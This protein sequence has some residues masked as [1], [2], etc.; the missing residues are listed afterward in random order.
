MLPKP[1][2]PSPPRTRSPL[3]SLNPD[4]STL[5]SPPPR[6]AGAARVSI[7]HQDGGGAIV[8]GDCARLVTRFTAGMVQNAVDAGVDQIRLATRIDDTHVHLICSDSGAGFDPTR[9]LRDGSGIAHLRADLRSYGAELTM[10][11]APCG[12]LRTRIPRESTEIRRALPTHATATRFYAAISDEDATFVTD[13]G[14]DLLSPPFESVRSLDI[15]FEHRISVVVAEGPAWHSRASALSEEFMPVKT[16]GIPL[17]AVVSPGDPLLAV[18]T[19]TRRG[20]L[21]RFLDAKDLHT[22]S[23][24]ALPPLNRFSRPSFDPAGR[25][26]LV[27]TA[28]GAAV[29]VRAGTGKL[30]PLSIPGGATDWWPDTSADRLI[31]VHLRDR[32]MEIH[33]VC[34]GTGEC[35]LTR[36]IGIDDV[37]ASTHRVVATRVDSFGSRALVLI[38]GRSTDSSGPLTMFEIDLTSE[39]PELSRR[40][41]EDVRRGANLLDA[42][43]LSC[44]APTISTTPEP[45]A[46][47]LLAPY[48]TEAKPHDR[49][50]RVAPAAL[51]LQRF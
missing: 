1:R 39:E 44:A 15:S 43:W 23:S 7:E 25:R 21:L 20:D 18:T 17:A 14:D 5:S 31:R 40:E 26:V 29:L 19:A 35:V 3:A 12:S 4:R 24:V 45:L 47:S 6:G 34:I 22:R 16:R 48:S 33:S 32:H 28:D 38:R 27:P 46:T 2:W 37:A 50:P 30:T 49:P 11:P 51:F 41:R 36:R 10:D 8:R 42:A 13:D 9:P